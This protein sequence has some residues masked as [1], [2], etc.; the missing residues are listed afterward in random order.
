MCSLDSHRELSGKFLFIPLAHEWA[1]GRCLV[2]VTV[3]KGRSAFPRVEG[4]ALRVS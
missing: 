2:F 4:E 1:W 3:K